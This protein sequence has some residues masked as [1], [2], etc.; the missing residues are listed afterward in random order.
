VE[1]ERAPH[2]ELLMEAKVPGGKLVRLRIDKAGRAMLSGDFFIY[3]E[4]GIL[5]IENM[6]SGLSGN[7]PLEA[8]ESALRGAVEQN[9]LELVGLD[10]PV[11]ARLYK[12][13]I[14]VESHKP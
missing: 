8:V 2:R 11:I 10:I 4:D 12:G 6:L 5:I 9:G 7:E 3:P 1:D 13:A 14:D